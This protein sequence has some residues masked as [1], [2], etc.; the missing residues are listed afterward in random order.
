MNL[1]DTCLDHVEFD[2]FLQTDGE[3]VHVTAVH[4]TVC[5]EAFERD[6]EQLGTF[7]PVFLICC[8]ETA[9]VDE[10]VFLC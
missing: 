2:I 10:S 5:E 6:A 4:T 3:S 9:H 8:D 7:V 1:F